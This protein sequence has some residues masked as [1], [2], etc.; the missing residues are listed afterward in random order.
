MTQKWSP[1]SWKNYTIKQLPNYP[2]QNKLENVEK[3]LSNFPPLVFAGEARS[4]Q[5]QLAKVSEG[6]G[7]LLQGGDCAESFAEHSADN[8]RDTFRVL[9]QMASTMTFGAKC[10]I[11][12]VG[13]MAGQFAK[14]RSADTETI[15]G[16]ELPS[17]RGDIVNGIEFDAQKRI[18]DPERQIS[19]LIQNDKSQLIDNLLQRLTFYDPLQKEDMLILKKFIVGHNNF[20]PTPHKGNATKIWNKKLLNL[21]NL[22]KLAVS[23]VCVPLVGCR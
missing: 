14:P 2:D 18:P 20:L 16:V 15:D 8:I 11:V 23:I 1:N 21:S 9:M 17:Y 13:R 19:F 7:F 5:Q 6:K 3:Q 22:W 4:L 12:K 10:P